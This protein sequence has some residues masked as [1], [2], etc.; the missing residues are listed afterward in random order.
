MRPNTTSVK[1][2]AFEKLKKA[3]HVE[4][5]VKFYCSLKSWRL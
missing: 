4:K 1:K 2:E 5:Y 3:E